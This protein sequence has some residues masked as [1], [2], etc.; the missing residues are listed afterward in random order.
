[1]NTV[2]EEG[3]M[4][5]AQI[6]RTVLALC[7]CGAISLSAGAQV[8]RST[9]EQRARVLL[10]QLE[11]QLA[12]I[13]NFHCR[14]ATPQF[15]GQGNDNPTIL[16]YRHEWLAADRQG[17]GRVTTTEAGNRYSLTWDGEKTIEHRE[18]MDPNGVITHTAF[19][20]QGMQDQTQRQNE[21]WVYLGS[22]LANL[23]TKALARKSIVRVSYT[24]AGLHRVDVRDDAGRTHTALL[25]PKQGY[26]PIYRRLFANGKVLWQETITFQPVA[27]KPGLWFPSRVQSEVD[28]RTAA[29]LDAPVLKCTFTNVNIGAWEFEGMF[30]TEFAEGTLVHDRIRGVSY[31][32]G[33][34]NAEPT[35]DPTAVTA[36]ANEPATTTQIAAP[37]WRAAF[38]AAYRLDG[39]QD[40]KCII[41]PFIPER[42]QY[43]VNAEP[44]LAGQVDRA[45]QNRIYQFQWTSNL[46]NSEFVGQSRYLPLSTVLE[47]VVGLGSY[48]YEGLPHLLRLPLTGDWIVRTNSPTEQLLATL[49]QIVKA[50]TQWSIRFVKEQAGVI[51]IRASGTYRFTALAGAIPGDSVQVYAGQWNVQTGETRNDCGPM[52]E[53]L[54]EVANS[55]GMR[56][57]DET[58]SSKVDLCWAGHRS[59]ELK[60]LRNAPGLYNARVAGLLNNLTAQTGLT[61]RIELG[62][63]ERWRVTNPRGVT[64]RSN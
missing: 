56:I 29:P 43:L 8:S 46:E 5:H 36:D 51:V 10:G 18:E 41:P 22:D 38:D 57:I 49:E 52:T 31:V 35:A 62:D 64:A 23:M 37:A 60:S 6:V 42:T 20:V 17:R 63:I 27:G 58:Q 47:D 55:I 2:H 11:M 32:V 34:D 26:A 39:D 33:A 4:M 3:T 53:F 9:P 61:F 7:V 59:A 54:D 16:G 24:R 48:E 19:I 21:P 45:I 30:K 15:A 40:L 44:T 12:K 14:K 25:D 28:S 50:Q 13:K 1:M